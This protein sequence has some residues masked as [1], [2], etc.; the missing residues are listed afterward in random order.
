LTAFS[1]F[2]QLVAGRT[3]TEL[4]LSSL[5]ADA[6]MRYSTAREWLSVLEAS[7]IVR[8]LASEYPDA[9]NQGSKNP[10]ARFGPH[11]LSSGYPLDEW[12]A[13]TSTT[14]CHIRKL[15]DV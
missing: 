3:A 12:T 9:T 1:T 4:N 5:G 2:L 13:R 11:L 10:Y 7:F 14:R 15:G 6:G 8:R